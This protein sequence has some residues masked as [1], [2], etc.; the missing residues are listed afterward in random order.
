[1]NTISLNNR[2]Y[3]IRPNKILLDIPSLSLD[4]VNN[5]HVAM[6]VKLLNNSSSSPINM[7]LIWDDLNINDFYSLIFLCIKLYSVFNCYHIFQICK[8]NI[9]NFINEKNNQS[10]EEKLLILLT[11]NKSTILDVVCEFKKY[12]T[13][14]EKFDACNKYIKLIDKYETVETHFTDNYTFDVYNVIDLVKFEPIDKNKITIPAESD[15]NKYKK[16]DVI[17]E[18]Y[19]KFIE[20]YKHFTNEALND[21]NWDNVIHTGS[22][23]YLLVNPKIQPNHFPL[24]SDIDLFIYGDDNQIKINKVNYLCNYFYQKY[25]ENVFFCKQGCVTTVIIRSCD[26]LNAGKGKPFYR[27]FQIINTV[28]K[29]PYN[30]IDNFDLSHAQIYYQNGRLRCSRRFLKYYRQMCSKIITSKAIEYRLFKTSH[31]GLHIINN[32]KITIFQSK[33]FCWITDDFKWNLTSNFLLN[34]LNKYYYPLDTENDGRIIYLTS[35]IFHVPF[36]CVSKKYININKTLRPISNNV[37]LQNRVNHVH[38]LLDTLNI[39]T[40]KLTK[41]NDYKIMSGCNDLDIKLPGLPIEKIYYAKSMQQWIVAM[42]YN[43]I[44]KKL[45][46][47][48]DLIEDKLERIM[49]VKSQKKPY[50]I[51]KK[52]NKVFLLTDNQPNDKR[53]RVKCDPN[54]NTFILLRLRAFMKKRFIYTMLIHGE[55]LNE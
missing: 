26:N 47:Y 55:K 43:K 18:S 39:Q 38:Q 3:L 19:D 15:I 50:I 48:I 49:S 5:R 53:L 12:I 36:G 21:L 13:K 42:S 24:S 8:K 45:I 30:V 46:E 40:K 20:K 33:K 34:K 11:L 16:D 41:P 9:N 32:N 37:Y 14:R 51:N 54:K 2:Q 6:F 23:L 28:H 44:S 29:N 10:L 7:N 1:M 31:N 25:K 35:K 4:N 22:S 27:N 52:I 17:F